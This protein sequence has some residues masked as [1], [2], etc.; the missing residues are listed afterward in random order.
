MRSSWKTLCC[1]LSG[2]VLATPVAMAD[3]ISPV[4]FT[5]QATNSSGTASF[6]IMSTELVENAGVYT[7]TGSNLPIGPEYDPI[8]TLGGAT[9]TLAFGQ[10]TRIGLTANY[11]SGTSDTTFSIQLATLSFDD[12]WWGAQARATAS[13]GVTDNN[14][15][16]IGRIEEVPAGSGDGIHQTYYNTDT[17]FRGQVAWADV[18]SGGGSA[19]E[20]YPSSG[21]LP[22]AGG[23]DDMSVALGFT[24]TAGDTGSSTTNFILKTPEPTSMS[25]FALAALAMARRRR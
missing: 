23:V 13:I 4:V 24:L 1:V 16:S 7:W 9:L 2:L 6:D 14:H 20:N 5:I 11:I 12:P 25:L 17:L 10:Y 22:V 3:T 19:Y 15:D 8:A 21:F 18:G